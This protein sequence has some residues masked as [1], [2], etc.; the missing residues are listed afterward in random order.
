MFVVFLHGFF[1][2]NIVAIW[3][4]K[5]KKENFEAYASNTTGG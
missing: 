5:S 1:L 4:R 3:V 2:H